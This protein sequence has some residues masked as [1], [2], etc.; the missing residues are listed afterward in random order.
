MV[1]GC[2]VVGLPPRVRGNLLGT[3]RYWL[4]A[5]SIPAKLDKIKNPYHQVP[6]GPLGKGLRTGSAREMI[7]YSH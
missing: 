3:V 5:R 1:N 4:S 2:P 6:L 7:F